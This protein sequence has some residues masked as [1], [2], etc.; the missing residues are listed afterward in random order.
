MG[1]PVRLK[2]GIG[3]GVTRLDTVNEWDAIYSASA[4]TQLYKKL[5]VGIQYKGLNNKHTD[6]QTIIYALYSF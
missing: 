5:G 2:A 3:Y 1:I 4:E 6:N